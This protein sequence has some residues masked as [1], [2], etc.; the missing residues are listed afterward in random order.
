MTRRWGLKRSRRMKEKTSGCEMCRTGERL[1]PSV[2]VGLPLGV[3]GSLTQGHAPMANV[4][5]GTK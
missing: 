4:W 5:R 1:G 3:S 2:R